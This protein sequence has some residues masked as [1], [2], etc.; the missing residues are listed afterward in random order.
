MRGLFKIFIFLFMF[1][2]LVYFNS[3]NNKFLM[4]DYVF[5]ANP[6]LSS[7]NFISSQWN[8]YREQA[9]GVLEYSEIQ[10][11]YRPLAHMLYD[12]CYAA[13]KNNFWQHHLLNLFLFVFAS[14]FIYLLIKK[15]T[16]NT[17]LAF[18]TALFYLIHPINGIVVNYISASVF[19]LQV[20]CML[21]TILLLW[22]SLERKNNRTLY[23]L[24]LLCSFLSLFW[25]ESGMMVPLYVSVVVVLFRDGPYKTK[26]VQLFPYYLIVFS[27]IIFRHFFLSTNDSIL[28]LMALFHMTLGVY[29]A[30]LFRIFSWYITRLFYP[31]GIVIEWA[32]VLHQN[33]FWDILGAI[34]MLLLFLLLFWSF[35][36]EKICR[37]AVIWILI[38]FVPACLAAFR[39]PNVGV[40]IEPH[41]FI[42]S[43]IG[44]FILAAYFCLMILGHSKKLGLVLLFIVI[45]T[46]CAVSHAYNKLWSDQKTYALF[47]SRQ[48]PNLKWTFFY[49]ANA[50][51]KEGAFKEA[52]KYYQRALVGDPS[53]IEIYNNLGFMDAQYGHGK[54]AELNFRKVLN[55]NPF[56]AAAYNNLGNLYQQQGQ[57]KKAEEYFNRSLIL[58]PLLI[59]PRRSLASI[60]LA[61]SE[62]MKATGLCLK[63][64][65]IVK[66]DPGT[67]FLLIDIYIHEKYFI[68][69]KK[70]A[71]R[72][73]NDENDPEILTNLG[74]TMSRNNFFSIAIDSYI[75]A[76]RVGPDYKDAYFNAGTLLANMGKYDKAI[77]VW[78]IGLKIDPLDQRFKTSIAK[79]MTLNLK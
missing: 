74:V 59:E 68:N 1:G 30:S 58:N 39:L 4:D 47:W 23:F 2:F 55:F 41:W 42:F 24:S 65:D 5:L 31:Q 20:I 36:K 70:Y 33:I 18:L 56:S 11:Y 37:L 53:D 69:I 21:G 13:F 19:S 79:A 40:Y 60:F 22:E 43:S 27:Y 26:A 7:M 15:V 78:Q 29:L 35:A 50:Y 3:L 28:K 73:I 10:S 25:H 64:L 66:D 9:S 77:L 76:M 75:K 8:P 52:R 57:W 45:F 62:Y 61:N 72:L 6:V 34:S 71:Y 14:S 67:L 49:L 32:P 17:N 48:V 63:N 16:G 38:G 46:W 12:F 44:F 51:Q 54:E